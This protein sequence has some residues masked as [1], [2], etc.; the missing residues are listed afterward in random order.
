MGSAASVPT[1]RNNGNPKLLQRTETSL[2]RGDNLTIFV[3]EMIALCPAID[4]LSELLEST[5]GRDAFI[6]F[7]RDEY[8]DWRMCYLRNATPK[9]FLICSQE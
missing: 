1:V 3:D 6:E 5:V 8:V 9:L 7:L 4:G 2:G